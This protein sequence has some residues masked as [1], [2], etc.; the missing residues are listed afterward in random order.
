LQ[1]MKAGWTEAMPAFV[2]QVTLR[3]PSGAASSEAFPFWQHPETTKDQSCGAG[4][5]V[6]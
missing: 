3:R 4:H 6:F 5:P 1:K 2:I